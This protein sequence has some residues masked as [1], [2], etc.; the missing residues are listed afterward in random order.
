MGEYVCYCAPQRLF[1]HSIFMYPLLFSNPALNPDGTFDRRR[2]P[3]FTANEQKNVALNTDP[4]KVHRGLRTQQCAL[5]NRFLPR[6]LNI[7][8]NNDRTERTACVYWGITI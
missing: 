7:T 2:W 5:W 6:L 3:L 8:G 1:T 4:L